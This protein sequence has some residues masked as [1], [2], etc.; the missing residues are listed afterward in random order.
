MSGLYEVEVN[1]NFTNGRLA[2]SFHRARI[3]FIHSFLKTTASEIQATK[4]ET[5]ELIFKKHE[6][7]QLSQLKAGCCN[8][9]NLCCFLSTHPVGI[10]LVPSAG[11]PVTVHTA[12]LGP[13]RW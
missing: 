5:G 10:V 9:C 8:L 13:G 6:N 7:M 1:L 12:S 4:K 11:W 3:A 2:I